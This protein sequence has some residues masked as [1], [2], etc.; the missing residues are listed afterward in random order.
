[1]N[2]KTLLTI[3]AVVFSFLLKA[4]PS[5]STKNTVTPGIINYKTGM[6]NSQLEKIIKNQGT[7]IE[8]QLGFWRFKLGNRELTIVTD[9]AHNRMRIMTPIIERKNIKKD[10]YQELLEAMFDRALDVK[11]ALYND[12]LWSVF[13]HPLKELTEEQVID[14][15]S[16]VFYAAHNF[17]ESYVSTD[18]QFGGGEK[19]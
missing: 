12:V 2:T 7:I 17:G 18:L 4:E 10:Q 3:F 14:A 5:D 1:M 13:I 11:Y 19:K 6:D 8:G 15:L 9:E 16:Q